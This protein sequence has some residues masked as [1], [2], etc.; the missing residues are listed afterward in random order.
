MKKLGI[1]LSFLLMSLQAV[2]TSSS[3]AHC[4]PSFCQRIY[5]YIHQQP[6]YMP[7]PRHHPVVVHPYPLA[8]SPPRP[9]IPLTRNLPPIEAV[10][11]KG[12]VDLQIIGGRS[13]NKISVKMLYPGLGVKV[14]NGALYISNLKKVECNQNPRP[15]IKLYINRLKE[16][17]VAGDSIIRGWHLNTYCGL[18][19]N[20]C[21]SG[22]F[23]LNG[24]TNLVRLV[25]SGNALIY[26]PQVCSQ[27]IHILATSAGVVKLRGSTGLL[28][29]RAFQDATVDTRFM[30]SHTAMVQASH[31]ALVTVH[32]TE[33]LQAFADMMSNVY[34]YVE[35]QELFQHNSLSG[36][37]FLM[38]GCTN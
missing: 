17:D 30:C 1:L 38:E 28:L 25:S 32:A 22:T 31:H 7:R 33:S 6:V 35:P 20:H 21:G 5:R 11:I 8:M 10:F 36:N 34:Y 23:C 2:A 19:I 29:I 18:T 24:P 13:A 37:V 9:A 15:C 16:I 14:C 12:G 27:H 4:E 3:S 26:I